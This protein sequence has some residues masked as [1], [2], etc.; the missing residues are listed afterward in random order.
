MS[1]NKTYTRF[2]AD[3]RVEHVLLVITFGLL[4]LSGIPQKFPTWGLSQF[5][6]NF[7][8][9][10]ENMR[11]VHHV[12]A[13]I[14]MLQVIYH[15]LIAFYKLYV[16]RLPATM[17]PALKD[18]RDG[19]DSFLYNI[20]IRKQR[21]HMPRYNFVEKAEY[22]AMI[23]GLIVMGLS[24][25]ILWNPISSTNVLPGEFVPAAKSAH[26]YEAV[27]AVLAII[28]W[29]FYSVHLRSWNW[30]MI[31]GKMKHEEMEEEHSLELE[32]IESSAAAAPVIAP[33]V[34]RK[35]RMIFFPVSL[36]VTLVGL[37]V[38]FKWITVEQTAVPNVPLAIPNVTPYSP[39]TRTP[40]A[41]TPTAGSAASGGAALTWEGGIGSI[42]T[43]KCGMCHGAS[44][45]V[46]LQT[47][48]DAMKA[49]TA[50]DAAGSKVITAQSLAVHSGKFTAEELTQVTDW[51][52]AGAPEK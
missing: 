11:S 25:F 2:N 13:I 24:G 10:I 8:G 31:N 28:V 41:P 38:V 39:V 22:W 6:V 27:L 37:F 42:I 5:M 12:S 19:I 26:G 36:V 1:A 15:L 45:G 44:G 52:T 32:Q 7:F 43:T 48:A 17:L 51:I 21:P 4:A 16:L 34:L 49:V 18:G 14:T 20:G 3:R 29:H 40:L 23:W 35:R 30:S 33:D 47:Y 9:G 46:S 50:G